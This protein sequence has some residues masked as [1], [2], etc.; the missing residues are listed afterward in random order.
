M[1]YVCV[2]TFPG[3]LYYLGKQQSQNN[4]KPYTCNVDMSTKSVVPDVLGVYMLGDVH[5]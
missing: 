5:S 2:S 4:D 3:E 1:L